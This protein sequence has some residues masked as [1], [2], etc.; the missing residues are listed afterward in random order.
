M[1]THVAETGRGGKVLPV[2]DELL[3]FGKSISGI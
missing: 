3:L 1:R 2:M